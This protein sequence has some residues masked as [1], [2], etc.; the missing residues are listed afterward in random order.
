[1]KLR[2]KRYRHTHQGKTYHEGEAFE[3][4]E[5]L[6]A[7]LPDRLESAEKPSEPEPEK[8]PEEGKGSSKKEAASKTGVGKG[9]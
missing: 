3:G 1:M 9:D 5:K 4:T 2:V 6:L 7:S 8:E